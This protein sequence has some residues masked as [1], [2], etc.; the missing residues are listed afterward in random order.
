MRKGF[1][2]IELLVVVLIIGIL[3]A[4][5]LPQ[6]YKAVEKSRISETLIL[7]RAL[8]DA[9]ERHYL[10]RGFYATN[11]DDLDLQLPAGKRVSNTEYVVKGIQYRLDNAHIFA[12]PEGKNSSNS[13]Y[14]INFWFYK[15]DAHPAIVANV[16]NCATRKNYTKGAA[17]CSMVG[18]KDTSLAVGTLSS[19]DFYRID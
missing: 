19:F 4:I 11:W 18:T 16:V 2:L 12:R 10:S 7:G 9:Q 6:Y 8:R 14:W 1:T 13:D 17:I 15:Q 5:A 3:A